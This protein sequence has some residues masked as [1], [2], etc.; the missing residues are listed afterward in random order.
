MEAGLPLVT[1]LALSR[2]TRP[3]AGASSSVR[4]LKAAA[5]VG[6]GCPSFGGQ[7][8][9]APDREHEDSQRLS[10]RL[11]LLIETLSFESSSSHQPQGLGAFSEDGSVIGPF[12]QLSPP[13]LVCFAIQIHGKV[14]YPRAR[15]NPSFKRTGLRPAV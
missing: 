8:T 2:K 11:S 13:A 6:A 5:E 9:V 1:L 15:P 3:A 10:R 14:A 4:P 7:R 12:V